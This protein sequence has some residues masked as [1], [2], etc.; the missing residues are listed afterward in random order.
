MSDFRI[1][2]GDRTHRRV[3]AW[4][5]GLRLDH[6]LSRD[7]SEFT[8]F[9]PLDNDDRCGRNTG[10][11]V[12]T[13]KMILNP[14]A[15]REGG[16]LVV[17]VFEPSFRGCQLEAEILLPRPGSRWDLIEAR[18]HVLG[19]VSTL[20][21]TKVTCRQLQTCCRVGQDSRIRIYVL[22]VE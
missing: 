5:T 18:H 8:R 15:Y 14:H 9:P 11:G 12:L 22:H 20:Q 13:S 1:L 21:F 7:W 6:L 10:I 17:G 3:F 4:I 2:P 19:Y 16:H